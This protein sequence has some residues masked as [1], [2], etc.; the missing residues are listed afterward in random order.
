MD[1]PLKI[2]HA[3]ATLVAGEAGNLLLAVWWDAPSSTQMDVVARAAA[4]VDRRY[5]GGSAFAQFV[6]TGTPRFSSD[7]RRKAQ[8]MSG[9]YSDLGV[10][11][12]IEVG[13]LAGSAARAFL[14]ALILIAR[15]ETPVRVFSNAQEGAAWLTHQ[16][17]GEREG[18]SVARI[19]SL[20]REAVDARRP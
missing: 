10:A 4:G 19:L 11:H 12:I 17:G 2:L 18:W 13:G 20:R 16:L 14:S 3:D 7:V 6:I 1:A 8:E 9:K 5:R 15:D